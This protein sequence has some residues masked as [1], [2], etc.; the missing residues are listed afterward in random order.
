MA[1][2]IT[3]PTDFSPA[4]Q[5]R[6]DPSKY[7]ALADFIDEIN[8]PDNR[9]SLV[10]TYGDQGITG[11]LQMT[12]A[13]KA[14]GTNDE[15]Q[16]WEETR[17]HPRQ[18]AS[19]S[20][21]TAS[22]ATSMNITLPTG[23]TRV[24]RN[25][26]VV[27]FNGNRRG[28]ISGM[29]SGNAALDAS[30]A[31]SATASAVL[32]VLDG[33]LGASGSAGTAITNGLSIIGNLFAQGS[34]QNDA[35][36]ESQVN[37]K[38]NKYMI[39]K[40]TF[41]V[42]GSQATNIGWVNLGGGD[43]RWYVKGEADTRKRFMDKREMMMLLGQSAG[44]SFATGI[45]GSEGY[46]AAI[47]DRGIVYNASTGLE[48]LDSLG[49]FDEI[50]KELDKQGANPEYAMY[51]NTALSLQI[52]D[53]IAAGISTGV[54]NGVTGQFG[55]FNNDRELAANLGFSSF[56]RG[57]YTFH[58]HSWKLLNE[59]TLLADSD[60]AGVMIPMSTVVDPKTG[61][62]NPAL[63][64]NFKSAGGYSRDMEHF[65]TGSILGAN[66]DTQDFAQFNYRSEVCLVTRAANR[67][68][69]LKS[70]V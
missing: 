56:T 63:E 4:A 32:N 53:M 31:Y 17:L 45:D 57:G 34:D 23:A 33:N 14:A 64:M 16:W 41:K 1:T 58:K 40:E 48:A 60:F 2:G 6:V 51:L 43:Y 61:D 11:F 12:G 5:R 66:T 37:K 21:N 68:V 42:T 39:M 20:S 52:D 3:S 44:N 24:L 10:K 67:H 18:T 8:K 19:A 22:T 50:V 25:N 9:E 47:E 55:A 70:V 30:G 27:L 26:D 65:I 59:P 38:T 49:E 36:L 46:F 28:F 62:R 7:T 54:T 29:A 15:V 69:L 13:T 35:Y